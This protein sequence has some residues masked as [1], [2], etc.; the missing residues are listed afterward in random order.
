[1]KRYYITRNYVTRYCNA[2]CYIATYSIKNYSVRKYYYTRSYN[3]LDQPHAQPPAGSKHLLTANL[4]DWP[5]A[6]P[7]I[8]C[9]DHVL[10]RPP[11]GL[12]TFWIVH[13]PTACRTD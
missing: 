7:T 3:L 1:M 6:R 11:A 13:Q 12:T 2:R 9:T 4:M 5:H 8:C 10:D